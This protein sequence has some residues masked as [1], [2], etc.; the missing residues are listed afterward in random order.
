MPIAPDRPRGPPLNALRAFEAAAR[1]ESFVLAGAELNVTPGAISQHVRT[2]EDWAGARLF[3]RRNNRVTLT[4]TGRDLAPVFVEAFD[5]IGKAVTALR[6]LRP[7]RE[8][9]IAALPSIAQLWLPY[10]LASVRAKLP[11]LRLSVTALERPPNLDREL[12]DLSLFLEGEPGSG[13]VLARDRLYPVCAPTVGA[14]VERP[15]DLWGET[16]LLDQRWEDDWD[17]WAGALGVALP[18]AA[19]VARYSLYSLALEEA[20]AGAGVLMGHACLV[21]QA[22]ADGSLVRAWPGEAESGQVL[23][24]RCAATSAARPEVAR[25]VELLSEADAGPMAQ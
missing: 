11:E 23:V 17:R 15:E 22:I 3:E 14:R 16:R 20:R 10:R 13:T 21:E 1:H 7:G 2:L 12:F 18:S 8:V 6:A 4:R 9:H 24:L 19:K 5:G 25:T